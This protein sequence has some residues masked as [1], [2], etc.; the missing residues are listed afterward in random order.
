MNIRENCFR[1]NGFEKLYGNPPNFPKLFSRKQYSRTQISELQISRTFNFLKP[2][3]LLSPSG[4]LKTEIRKGNFTMRS[5]RVHRTYRKWMATYFIVNTPAVGIHREFQFEIKSY[6][7]K[8]HIG[9]SRRPH[10]EYSVF[11]PSES[12]S[13][14]ISFWETFRYP[15]QLLSNFITACTF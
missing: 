1:E 10:D 6:E 13:Q 5:R 3:Y 12:P 14:L 2:I 4:M 7:R 9:S 11:R 15:K 8:F